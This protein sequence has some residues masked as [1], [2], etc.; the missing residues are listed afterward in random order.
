MPRIQSRFG[1]TLEHTLRQH[2][3]EV[4]NPNPLAIHLLQEAL[5]PFGKERLLCCC[6]QLREL[7]RL[8]N[9]DRCLLECHSHTLL[10]QITYTDPSQTTLRIS[11]AGSDAR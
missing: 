10:P 6:L 4:A 7:L 11:P 5:G 8:L 2:R 1:E 3:I 9:L